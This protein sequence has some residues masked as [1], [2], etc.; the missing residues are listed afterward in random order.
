MEVIA[1]GLVVVGAEH[2]VE[3]AAGA[4]MCAPSHPCEPRGASVTSSIGGWL[5]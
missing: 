5:P 4:V 1:V 2:Y 3:E